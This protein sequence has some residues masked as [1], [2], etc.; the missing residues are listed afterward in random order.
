MAARSQGPGAWF[1]RE[2]L[3]IGTRLIAVK[4]IATVRVLI[5]AAVALLSCG[6]D[7]PQV[8]LR[9]PADTTPQRDLDLSRLEVGCDSIR[10]PTS[11]LAGPTGA[12]SANDSAAAA[13]RALIA[14][15]VDVDPLPPSG[16]RRLY[17]DGEMVV[18][19]ADIPVSHAQPAGIIELTFERHGDGFRIRSSANGCLPRPHVPG[20]SL[21]EFTVASGSRLTPEATSID[22]VAT[23]LVCTSGTPLDDRLEPPTV[24]Y[25]DTAVE[26]LMTAAP[27]NGDEGEAFTC[28]SNPAAT[29]T[30][31]LD[32]PLG[33]RRLLDLS[34]Y[35]PRDAILPGVAG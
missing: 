31:K 30:L 23:E 1:R 26:V 22:I 20:R 2:P 7:G 35:P 12:E 28:V 11:A 17:D 9:S 4:R 32:E 27:L 10:Y 18:F 8:D 15:P 33:R 21:V 25:S 5:L 3:G 16:W 19:G 24:H 34:A 6:S 13:L 14:E 29:T